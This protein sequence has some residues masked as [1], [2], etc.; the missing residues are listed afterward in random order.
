MQVRMLSED[1]HACL[2][3]VGTA[4]GAAETDARG[5]LYH[6][7]ALASPRRGLSHNHATATAAPTGPTGHELNHAT[8]VAAPCTGIVI[9]NHGTALPAPR[10]G[11]II[12]CNHASAAAAPVSGNPLQDTFERSRSR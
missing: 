1:Q 8:A 10:D 11:L 6:A 12:I 2:A 7:T 9:F 3:G 4:G 5:N